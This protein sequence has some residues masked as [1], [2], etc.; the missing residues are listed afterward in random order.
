MQSVRGVPGKAGRDDEKELV[1]AVRIKYRG[2]LPADLTSLLEQR[3]YDAAHA[4]GKNVYA[5]VKATVVED[6]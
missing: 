6:V 3:A 2:E 5:R 4:R 1:I